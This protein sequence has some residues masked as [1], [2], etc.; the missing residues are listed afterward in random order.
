MGGKYNLSLKAKHK[1]KVTDLCHDITKNDSYEN[2]KVFGVATPCR[3][4]NI[5]RR[6]GR[7]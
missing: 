3:M 7:A 5:Y 1:P 6:S 2:E 4:V